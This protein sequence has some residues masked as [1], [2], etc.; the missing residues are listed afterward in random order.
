MIFSPG[1]MAAA[2]GAGAV[3]GAY[4]G[5]GGKRKELHF[6]FEPALVVIASEPLVGYTTNTVTSAIL[7]NGTSFVEVRMVGSNSSWI[8]LQLSWGDKKVTISA[9]GLG[10][11]AI[12]NFNK[13][14][15]VYRYVAFPKA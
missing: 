4:K 5:D 15:S 12:S 3:C 11:Q 7:V 14:N 1:I 13:T 2:G 10:D 8:C 6:D 9:G